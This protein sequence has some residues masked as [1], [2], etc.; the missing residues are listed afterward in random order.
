MMKVGASIS[1]I[2]LLGYIVL[3]KSISSFNKLMQ[4]LQFFVY[5][6]SWRISFTK[7]IEKC[8]SEIKRIVL[9]E[10]FDDFDLSK[11]IMNAL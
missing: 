10:Y 4:Q 11:K 1:I 7:N 9:T 3:N 8:L 6:L 2:I 5:I